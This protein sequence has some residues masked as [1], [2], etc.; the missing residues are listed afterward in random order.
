M[1]LGGAET[2]ATLGTGRLDPRLGKVS[3]CHDGP[4]AVRFNPCRTRTPNGA[5]RSVILAADEV[6]DPRD[7]RHFITGSVHAPSFQQAPIA[8]QACEAVF[9]R[10][11]RRNV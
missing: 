1:R 10:L 3:L 11:T 9:V 8:V 5:Y 4:Q 2:G 7:Q 6:P